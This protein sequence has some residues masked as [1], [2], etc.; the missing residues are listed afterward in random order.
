VR[1]TLL[2][3]LAAATLFSGCIAIEP[4][5]SPS[6]G[7]SG[8][9][10]SVRPSQSPA[11]SASTEPTAA[12]DPSDDL[13]PTD[14][15]PPDVT[16]T[17]EATPSTAPTQAPN[18]SEAPPT[19]GSASPSG[20]PAV[21]PSALPSVE[22]STGASTP[23][24]PDGSAGPTPTPRLR[25]GQIELRLE[26]VA[27]SP[28]VVEPVYITGD[29]TGDGRLYI[30]ERAGRIRV[31]DP[32]GKIR[33][34]PLLDLRGIVAVNGERGLHA[35]AFHPRFA[36][37]GRFFV[38][39]NTPDGATH[40]V[41]YR[42]RERGEEV[43]ASSGRQIMRFSRPEW[44][45]NGGWL[46][47]GPDGFLYIASG[48][49]GGNSPG[50]PFGNGQDRT[51]LLGSILRIDVDGRRPYTIP[52]DNPWAD[53]RR[54]Y[55]RELWNFGLRN[56]WRASFDRETGN[57]WIADVGQDAGGKEEVD[58][59]PAGR[60]GL[61]F[62]WSITE[63]TE[64]HGGGSCDRDGLTMPVA[65]YTNGG[66][67]AITGGYVYRGQGEPLMWGAYLFA[68]FCSG[69]IWGIPA[70]SARAGEDLRP[71]VL[72]RTDA[73]S[74]VSFGQDDAG[75]LYIVSLGGGIYRI[76]AREREQG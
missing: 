11:P 13:Q 52:R 53:G 14:Q 18:P 19:S 36:R 10:P 63:G 4:L 31:M 27:D 38:H 51:D 40:I 37:N 33:P 9:E 32:N 7:S 28:D 59:Q 74:W 42:Q 48:D 76:H 39:Y 17:P 44:N 65:E 61:N 25:L 24:S 71:R 64:C 23:P 22:P 49:G 72:Y 2:A 6:P 26:K 60:G 73:S 50:D 43:R 69:T 5:G 67:C 29:G 62:G 54:G 16:P 75:E 57:L 21:D 34:R 35:V 68:D 30:V 3:L 1:K 70:D 66:D 47:F 58:V 55:Q 20:P 45:H 8:L 41:E 56:P 12:P 15:Q 46:G